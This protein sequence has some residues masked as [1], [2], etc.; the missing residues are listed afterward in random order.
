MQIISSLYKR[1]RYWWSQPE[2]NKNLR[3]FIYLRWKQSLDLVLINIA[4]KRIQRRIAKYTGDD[5]PKA[6][7]PTGEKH[8]T[9]H[10]EFSDSSNAFG[11]M[12]VSF[13]KETEYIMGNVSTG[14]LILDVG[15]SIGAFTGL[16]LRQ[17]HIV[18][19]VEPLLHNIEKQASLFSKYL[20]N[21]KLFMFNIA[22]SDKVGFAPLWE[23]SNEFG[24][25]SSLEKH[26]L[27][28]TF[29]GWWS[30]N[31]TLVKTFPL[32]SVIR[33]VSEFTGIEKISCVKIDTEG[34]EA[35][36]IKGLFDNLVSISFPEIVM[37]EFNNR[38]NNRSYFYESV[39][40][41]REH[42]YRR[43]KYHIRHGHKLLYESDFMEDDFDISPW[44]SGHGNAIAVR[45]I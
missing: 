6:F 25:F 24:T 12:S 1:I 26:W 15:S 30:R 28:D 17:G 20:I 3:G 39:S 18:V 5:K 14:G 35:K 22:C 44:N 32:S 43:I 37:F 4:L 45:K 41:L 42:G 36:V 21:R 13:E 29:P 27:I 11:E 10:K 38:P 7:Y 2:R 31:I 19:S 33:A 40:L 34:H 9:T 23:S 16:F 8:F